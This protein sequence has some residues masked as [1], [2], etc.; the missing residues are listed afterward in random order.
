MWEW[1][2]YLGLGGKSSMV[3]EGSWQQKFIENLP[4]VKKPPIAVYPII[5][6]KATN[7]KHFC[8][9]VSCVSHVLVPLEIEV[10]Q[11]HHLLIKDM[12][13]A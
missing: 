4:R 1:N 2:P 11:C 12:D 9:S 5:Y 13:D 6:K 3:S 8:I 7:S 10:L